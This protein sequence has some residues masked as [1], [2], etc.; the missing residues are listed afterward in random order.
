MERKFISWRRVSTGKQARSGLGL[1]A[2]KSIIKYFVDYEKGVLIAD[3]EECHTGTSLS[4]CTELKKAM[5]HCKREDACLIIAKVD[6]FRTV[7]EALQILDYMGEG[8]IMFCDLP[9]SDRFS[10]TLY[11]ALAEREA[12]LVSIRTKQALAEKK[13]QGCL[14]GAANPKYIANKAKKD[15]N[16]IKRIEMERGK[17]KNR[18][19]VESKESQMFLKALKKAFPEYCE[20]D[21]FTKWEWKGLRL[22]CG[23]LEKLVEVMKDFHDIDPTVFAKWDFDSPLLARRLRAH[24][25]QFKKSVENYS[26]NN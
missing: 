2:Q 22:R 15:I 8:N 16:E 11:T 9:T 17:L 18:R 25:Q 21:D 4:T 14:L 24:M 12:L 19:Y 10:L 5:E 13:K 3:Y 26:S 6:R 23:K 20:D 7:I 1:E